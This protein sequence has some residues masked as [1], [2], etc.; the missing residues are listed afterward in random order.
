MCDV[1]L[2]C[3]AF[4]LRTEDLDGIWGGLTGAERARYASAD[5]G[6]VMRRR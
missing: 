4:A 5:F 2:D 6:S 3:L 1:R